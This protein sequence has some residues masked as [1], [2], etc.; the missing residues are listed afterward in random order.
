MAKRGGSYAFCWVLTIILMCRPSPAMHLGGLWKRRKHQQCSAISVSQAKGAVSPLKEK[1]KPQKVAAVPPAARRPSL[2]SGAEDGTGEADASGQGETM[3]AAPRSSRSLKAGWDGSHLYIR[4]ARRFEVDPNGY[5]QL[6]YRGYAGPTA[7]Q[8]N[9]VLRRAE[10][11]VQGTLGRRYGFEFSVEFT[12]HENPQQT[13]DLQINY[14]PALQLKLGRFKEPFSREE[15]VSSRYRAF[16]ERA[17]IN[18]LVP[19]YGAGVMMQGLIFGNAVQYQ[20]GIF[21]GKG[22]LAEKNSTAP[23]GVVRVRYTPWLRSHRHY[24]G[25]MTFGSAL[26]EGRTN[27]GESFTSA[28][29]SGSFVFFAHEPV[30]G[31]VTR[32]NG[33]WTW[34]L[35]PA[36]FHAEYIQT[37]QDRQGI[38]AGGVNL[39]G[40]VAKGY[41][42]DATCLVT[43]E[44]RVE[45]D[46]PAPHFPVFGRA[47]K[48]LG[49]W[50][51]K[52]R[53]STLQ[54]AD[55]TESNRVDTLTPGLNWYLTRFV[56]IMLDLNV[57][58]LSKPVVLPVPKQPGTLLSAL[59]TAQ[60]RF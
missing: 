47:G 50:E 48:G 1:S 30:N 45:D 52:F 49:A 32:A 6:T 19:G 5:A 3:G 54:M 21:G 37:Q 58:R 9:F 31:R 42:V 12:D 59:V 2:P 26:A 23:D 8:E 34:L 29:E 41:Y 33:E 53:Y 57:E 11:G 56:R 22:I 4:T 43:G 51:A 44:K 13:A 14:K 36:G 7:P 39:P 24:L 25:G 15:L 16:A 46:Q 20:V 18:N 55:G 38:G 10:L 35:G 60:V 17:M 27:H 28:T 40:V